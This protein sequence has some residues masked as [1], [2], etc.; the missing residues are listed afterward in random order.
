MCKLRVALETRAQDYQIII[1][2]N[3]LGSV[4]SLVRRA[5]GPNSRRV[6]IV[7][8]QRVFDLYGSAVVQGLQTNDFGVSTPI[9][10]EG[11]RFKSLNSLTRIL[12]S[13]SDLGLERNDAIVALGGGVVGDLAGFAA[14]VYLRGLPYF[15]VPTTLL[16][17]VDSSVGGKTAVNLPAGKNL[18]GAF[19]QPRGVVIDTDTLETLPAREL[20]AGRCEMVKNGAVGGS[21]L[22]QQT[23]AL[24]AAGETDSPARAKALA[25]LI[26]AHCA[27][28]AGIVAGDEREALGRKDRRSRR[29]LNF[30]HTIG[31]A[32]EAVT[33]YRHFRHGEAVGYG[34]LVEG[35][36]SKL[37]GLLKPSELES[38]RQVVGLCG[39]LPRANDLS[40]R[41]IISALGRDKKSIGGTVQWV[42][43]EKIGSARIV[44]GKQIAPSLLRKALKTVLKK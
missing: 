17:Q 33:K 37:L 27:F 9:V 4:G 11:E 2:R 42:L 16:A 6:V 40:E 1:G 39:P 29:I 36:I 26:A 13:L 15:Q 18:V 25:E 21:R 28:K 8:N 41:E 3:L 32:L 35:E 34:M 7:S 31:H 14:A 44:D 10:G 30:G 24:L 12:N 23:E 19:H 38:L 22:F 5:L 43:L 20:T